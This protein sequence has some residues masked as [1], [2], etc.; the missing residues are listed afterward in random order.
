VPSDEMLKQI[1]EINVKYEDAKEEEGEFDD[2]A[3]AEFLDEVRISN[4]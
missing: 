1:K 4:F 2:Y 3:F